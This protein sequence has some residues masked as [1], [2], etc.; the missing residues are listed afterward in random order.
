MA[1]RKKAATLMAIAL[2]IA[3]E[4]TISA[5]PRKGPFDEP[6]SGDDDKTVGAIGTL[7]DFKGPSRGRRRA[8]R[9]IAGICA[10]GPTGSLCS[11]VVV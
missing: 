7:G 6:T 5:D 9:L 3:C 2:E 10:V 1:S 11:F 8:L 4:P